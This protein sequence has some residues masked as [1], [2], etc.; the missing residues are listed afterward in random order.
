MKGLSAIT[1][2]VAV[3]LSATAFAAPTKGSKSTSVASTSATAGAATSTSLSSPTA[4]ATSAGSIGAT[5]PAAPA[6][7][8]SVDLYSEGYYGAR[9]M[10]TNGGGSIASASFVGVNYKLS[11]KYKAYIRQNFDGAFAADSKSDSKMN[12]QD[13]EL[14]LKI[15]KLAKWNNGSFNL[16]NRLYLPTGH[17]SRATEQIARLRLNLAVSQELG[18]HFEVGHLTDPRYAFHTQDQ[19]MLDGKMKKTTDSKFVQYAYATAK[20]NDEL[21][22]TVA[23]GTIDSWEKASGKQTSNG[24]LDIAASAQLTKAIGLTV[25][26][27]NE[28]NIG[29]GQEKRFSFMRDT[30]TEY[31]MNVFASM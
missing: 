14:A 2:A 29:K 27:D 6:K 28:P 3:T 19:Y 22:A 17:N 12:V 20:A 24:Y 1:L 26:V 11:D 5:L 21:S 15:A 4:T 25:G 18:K 8:W 31:Y 16:A 13:T 10:N 7:K 23:L 30:E 9:A